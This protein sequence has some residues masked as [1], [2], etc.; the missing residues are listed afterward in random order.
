MNGPPPE[1]A[2]RRPRPLPSA[3]LLLSA[4]LLFALAA[5]CRTS[6]A[7]LEKKREDA[8]AFLRSDDVLLLLAEPA[9]PARLKP[10]RTRPGNA[11]RDYLQAM[12]DYRRGARPDDPERDVTLRQPDA[13]RETSN[14]APF[15]EAEPVRRILEG[16][17]KRSCRLTGDLLEIGRWIVD[18]EVLSQ[19]ACWKWTFALVERARRLERAEKPA[20]AEQTLIRTLSFGMHLESDPALAHIVTG[21]LVQE[22]VVFYL[23]R[24]YRRRGR[25]DAFLDARAYARDLRRYGKPWRIAPHLSILCVDPEGVPEA[26]EWV[27]RHEN[28]PLA[29]HVAAAAALSYF[30]NLEERARGPA[31]ERF[32]ALDRLRETFDDPALAGIADRAETMLTWPRARIEAFVKAFMQGVEVFGG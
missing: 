31:A 6:P 32:Q 26:V 5:S 13:A 4:P 30:R 19:E 3:A 1:P 16:S 18:G 28:L 8:R 14:F 27:I 20:E 23:E 17:Q 21:R 29:L 10:E 7:P 15:A 9:L 22:E 24:F 11:G 12:A 2:N 25:R